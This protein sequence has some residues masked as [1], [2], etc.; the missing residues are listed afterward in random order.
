MRCTQDLLPVAPD[1]AVS[2]IVGDH[3]DDVGAAG[4]LPAE[5]ED[6]EEQEKCSA[7]HAMIRAGAGLATG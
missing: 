2:E 4:R 5:G 6:G 3:E 7:H 1:V